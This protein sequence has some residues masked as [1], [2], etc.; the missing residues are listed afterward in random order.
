MKDDSIMAPSTTVIS[1]IK[2][3]LRELN[4]NPGKKIVVSCDYV[5]YRC[6][7][8]EMSSAWDELLKKSG[9]VIDLRPSTI[10]SSSCFDISRK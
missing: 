2:D 9:S 3:I 6:V 8:D 7:K 10:S 4:H 1:M 5:I